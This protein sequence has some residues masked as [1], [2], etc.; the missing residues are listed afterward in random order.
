M[1]I[2][3]DASRAVTTRRTGTEAY[4]YFLIRALLPL[5]I[6]RGHHVKLYFNQPPDHPLSNAPHEVIAIPFPRLWTHLRLAAELQ[7]NPPDLF[8][9][10]AHVIP[11]TYRGTS[12]AT[13]HDLGYHYF[14][15]A[16]TSQQVRYLKWSTRHNAR[17]SKFVLADSEATRRDLMA[18]YGIDGAKIYTLYPGRDASLHPV[19]DPQLAKYDLPSP[20][21]LYIGTVQPRKNIPL[22][23]KAFA[24]V[25][26]QL[27]HHLVLAGKMGWLS[28]D[29]LAPLANF[30]DHIRARIHLPGFID[31]SDKADLL[32][33]AT[34]LLFPS[35]YE[36][37]GFPILEAQAC[38]TPVITAHNS[39]L[40]EVAG[41]AALYVRTDDRH[42]R[43]F[44]TVDT[45]AEIVELRDA[46][47]QIVTDRALRETL[48]GR[49]Y[50]N[51]QRFSWEKSA[52]KL[53]TLFEN[54]VS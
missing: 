16:H 44:A 13:V 11:F 8:F 14:P 29:A 30:P 3:I 35:L 50:E 1:V 27:P 21:F 37:F 47:R 17:R 19:A 9:T 40:P 51:V 48:I 7:R 15:E 52:E 26:D 25:A 32:S 41:N 45:G 42:D 43:E 4:A 18:W 46:M 10:P 12:V 53:I 54:A 20:Y 6:Q 28:N 23:L 22:I 38:G 33:G 5:A 39:S 2:G 49:G 31:D 36:G 34:A 24:A